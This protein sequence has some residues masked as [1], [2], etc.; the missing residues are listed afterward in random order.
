[1]RKK[2][3]CP[4]CQTLLER[5]Y[6]RRQTKFYPFGYYCPGCDYIERKT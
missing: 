6:N 1:M 3:S 2:P 5:L 4:H